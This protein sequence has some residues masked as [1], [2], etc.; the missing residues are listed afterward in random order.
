MRTGV[1]IVRP[2]RGHPRDTPVA[3]GTATL[4]GNGEMT[5]LEWVRESGLL[6][7]DIGITN[8]HSVGV[9]R[10]GLVAE[11]ERA[12][13]GKGIYWS[14]PVVG[15][16]YDGILND[17]EGRHVTAEHVREAIENLSYEDVEEGSVG[18]GTGMICHSFKGGIGTSSRVVTIGEE[19][20]TV[21]VLVQANHGD[22]LDLRFDG[23]PVGRHLGEDAVPMPGLAD[24]VLEKLKA[25]TGSIILVIA[26][27]AP[28]TDNQCRRLANR[29]YVGLARSGGG[30]HDGSGDIAIAFATGNLGA[31]APEFMATPS[32][33]TRITHLAHQEISPLFEATSEATEE[34][35]FNAL[36]QSDTTEGRD[37]ITV[38]ALTPEALKKAIADVRDGLASV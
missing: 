22:R 10:D 3:A 6:T 16:T 26:T 31:I 14:M 33:T 36:L 27:D 24:H 20:Y 1:T 28:L 34:A 32:A 15:E 7:T 12:S 37:W 13:S 8:T 11:D 35:I 25:G 5:G 38:Q 9:V 4:N 17:I 19:D 30:C 18:G 23:L 29:A 2:T 21:G